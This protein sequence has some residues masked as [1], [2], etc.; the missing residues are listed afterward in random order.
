M[1]GPPE[2][3]ANPFGADDPDRRA[4]W[5]MLVARDIEAFVAGDFERVAGD[6]DPDRFATVTAAGRPD[7]DSWTLALTEIEDYRAEWLR[8]S[9]QFRRDFDDPAAVLHA[10]TTLDQI[11]IKGQHALAHKRFDYVARTRSG[12][13]VPLRW[14]TL[15]QCRRPE[16]DPARWRITGFIGF[17]PLTLGRDPGTGGA[18]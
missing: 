9:E 14:R 1:T 3:P 16:N 13:P 4:L 2:P 17:L 5:D 11:E 10:A 15:Y 12:T 8:Q 18:G 7:P 6:F